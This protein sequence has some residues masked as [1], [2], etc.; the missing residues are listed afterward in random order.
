MLSAGKIKNKSIIRSSVCA[1]GE[2]Y[3]QLPLVATASLEAAASGNEGGIVY[4]STT[5]SVKFSNGTSWAAIAGSAITGDA[6]YNAGAW[7]VAVDANDV[8]FNLADSTNDYDFEL[9]AS[10]TGTLASALVVDAYHATAT[11][12]DAIIVKTTGA[13]A[14]VTDA[15]D[16][17]DA[18]IVNALNIG[19]NAI[20]GSSGT[21]D[22]GSFEVDGS[23]NVSCVNLTASG[24]VTLAAF[25][26]A[27]PITVDELILDTDGVAPAA[28]VCY[29]VRDN[30]GDLTVNCVTGKTVNVAVAGSDEYAFA[31][32]S[33]D[34]KG[35]HLD[36]SGYVIMNAVT[37][38]A[39]TECY[40]GHDNS[41]DTTVNCLTGKTINFA[42]AG[43]DEI[44]IA[45][46]LLQ[47]TAG[48]DIKF[49]DDGGL[50][51]S[52][53]NEV[54]LVEATG[55]AV[56]YL[57]VKNAATADP[58][59]LACMGTADK[60][61]KFENDQDE[62]IFAC[63]P[64]A[65]GVC[66]MDLINSAAAS[67]I[68]RATG[69]ADMGLILQNAASE[70][71]FQ[72]SCGGTAAVNWATLKASDTGVQVIMQ[73][74][75]EDDVG[76]LFNAKNAE[77]I[78]SL[79]T[80]AAAVDYIEITACAADGS[81]SIKALGD[82]THIDLLLQAKGTANVIIDQCGIAGGDGSGEDFVI[83]STT[84][85]TKGWVSVPNGGQ[86]LQIGGVVDRAGTAQDNTLTIVNAATPPQA[87]QAIVNAV[88]F[89]SS[90]GEAFVIDAAGTATQLSPHNDD[91]EWHFNSYSAKTGKTLRIKMER[92]MK[93]LAEKY[94]E[95]FADFIEEVDGVDV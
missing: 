50:L 16:M 29:A 45:A 47:I 56:N 49:M 57:Q 65:T 14:V 23:G 67:P 78:L 7:T 6:V 24:T 85:A 51:D 38:P 10:A 52:S 5:N 83:Q 17:S 66:Y 31:A 79:K 94:P 53:G 3:D 34:M 63:T 55:S 61:F 80:A 15:L 74:D 89:Y 35:N 11:I 37:L 72:V 59:S 39:G 28:T 43:T 88:Q 77:E 8:I 95:D 2:K 48:S 82:D 27:G 58:I 75:G 60:G 1:T 20:V 87:G 54:L 40:I 36:N 70:P 19:A 21:I 9:R 42:V 64:V 26:V 90:G 71:I 86:G 76:F 46:N 22:L 4:D 32:A 12:T 18:G 69:I 33:L 84:H 62:V 93:K 41:G 25:E 30:S 81:P 91:G 44:S 92:M 73:N 68:I 13:T